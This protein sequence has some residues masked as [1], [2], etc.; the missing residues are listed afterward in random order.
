MRMAMNRRTKVGLAAGA[1][2][3]AVAALVGLGP[4]AGSAVSAPRWDDA[5]AA[6]PA[7]LSRAP[8][9]G[10]IPDDEW[11]GSTGLAPDVSGARRILDTADRTAWLTPST[12]GGVCLVMHIHKVENNTMAGCFYADSLAKPKPFV[13]STPDSLTVGVVTADGQEEAEAARRGGKVVAPNLVLMVDQT[14]DT[15]LPQGDIAD[16]SRDYGS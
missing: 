8:Q 10:D 15:P 14:S 1:V 12:K 3:T 7:V 6:K 11:A 5:L 13:F 4:V 16:I 2:A 9:P